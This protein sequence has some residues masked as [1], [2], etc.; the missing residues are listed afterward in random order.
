MSTKKQNI[1]VDYGLR[2][3]HE[4]FKLEALHFGLF[5]P[6]DKPTIENLRKAQ[7][8]Y[9]ERLLHLIPKKTQR[10]LDAGCGTGATA[11][12][13][14]AAGYQVEC[15]NPD[16]YQA[17]VFR[18]QRGQDLTLHQVKFQELKSSQPYDLIMFSESAQYIPAD[19]LFAA[20]KNNLKPDGHILV[21]DYFRKSPGEYYKTCHVL[22]D[23]L[24]EAEKAG[25]IVKSSD[26][27]TR[28]VLPTL[29]VGHEVYRGYILPVLEIVAGLIEQK[30]PLLKKVAQTVFRKK[31]KKLKWYL[32]EKTEQ[33]LD[34]QRFEKEVAYN[35]ILFSRSPR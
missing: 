24:G 3:Y 21:S 1:Q 35:M 2:L 25:F 34:T 13:L 20:A 11:V 22:T 31:V 4:V 17:Q 18:E 23:F 6:E 9:T 29:V 28:A 30:A 5:E 12:Q 7:Q 26:D 19:Q 15:C 14:V 33:K 32:Y 16:A 8:R 10:I 27:I